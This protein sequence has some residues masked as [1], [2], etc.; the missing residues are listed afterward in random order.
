MRAGWIKALVYWLLTVLVPVLV[1]FNVAYAQQK[2]PYKLPTLELDIK[3]FKRFKSSYKP[4]ERMPL[5]KIFAVVEK[6]YPAP[7]MFKFDLNYNA[8]YGRGS[9]GSDESEGMYH[10]IVFSMPLFSTKENHRQREQEYKRR[11]D[12]S[13]LIADFNNQITK[14]NLALRKISLFTSLEKREQVRVST[15]LTPVDKQVAYLEKVADE[16]SQFNAAQGEINSIKLQ[17]VAHC[18]KRKKTDVSV[19]LDKVIAARYVD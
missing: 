10:S 1:L 2:P 8:R 12:L 3:D 9:A 19:F 7:S 14:R 6:C 16:H 5:S 11:Q 4:V 18:T 13:K 15:G 17:L